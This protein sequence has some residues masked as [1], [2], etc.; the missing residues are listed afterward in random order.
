MRSLKFVRLIL[1]SVLCM[2]V[3]TQPS[4]LHAQY[5][6]TCASFDTM[7][8]CC[9]DMS[10]NEYCAHNNCINEETGDNGDGTQAWQ[11]GSVWPS[12]VF[13]DR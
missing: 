8:E 7:E 9:A 4:L 5:G 2:L 6:T 12:F 1:L 10:G 13:L 3:W 11:F